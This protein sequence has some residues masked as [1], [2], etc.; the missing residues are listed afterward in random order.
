MP[1]LLKKSKATPPTAQ[2]V[3]EKPLPPATAAV[4]TPVRAAPPPVAPPDEPK[5][6][7]VKQYAMDLGDVVRE[8]PF[9]EQLT[10]IVDCSV[11]VPTGNLNALISATALDLAESIG[12][13]DIRLAKAEPYSYGGWKAV[14]AAAVSEKVQGGIY[15]VDSGELADPVI[16]IIAGKANIVIRG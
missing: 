13:K 1:F 8:T 3:D 4:A 6:T 9:S 10:L 16:E 14:L 2:G 7:A 11:S 15:T 12:V 5:P